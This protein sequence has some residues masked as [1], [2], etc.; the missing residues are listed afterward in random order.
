MKPNCETIVIPEN[1]WAAFVDIDSKKLVGL[2]EFKKGGKAHSK[3]DIIIKPTKAEV[4]AE[5][6]VILAS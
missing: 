4:E 5:L 1:S 2:S 3:L 6:A